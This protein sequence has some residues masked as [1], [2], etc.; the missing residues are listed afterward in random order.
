MGLI[1]L[2]RGEMGQSFWDGRILIWG[3]LIEFMLGEVEE[4]GGVGAVCVDVGV[5]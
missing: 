3:L 1:D 5:G 4:E 2:G